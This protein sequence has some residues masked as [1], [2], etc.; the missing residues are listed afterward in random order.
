MA[1]PSTRVLEEAIAGVIGAEL[2]RSECYREAIEQSRNTVLRA[3]VELWIA[4]EGQVRGLP[5]ILPAESLKER[6]VSC[7]QELLRGIDFPKEHIPAQLKV[8]YPLGP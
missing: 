8:R 4:E 2:R 5:V 3:Q 1:K 7:I 6:D